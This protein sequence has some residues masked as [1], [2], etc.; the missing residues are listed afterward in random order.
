MRKK[1]LNLFVAIGAASM[2]LSSCSTLDSILSQAGN[3]ANLANC[4]YNMKDVTNVYVAGVNVKN[5]VNGNISASDVLKLSSALLSKNVP[6]TMDVNIN[7]TNPTTTNA[8]LTTMDWICEIDGTQ[9]ANGTTS[10]NYTIK[11]STTTT[12]PLAVNTNVYSMFSKNGIESLK[13]F[14]NSFQSDGTSS[15]VAIK[16]KPS[17]NAGGINISS[18]SYITLEKKTGSNTSTN[19][20]NNGSTG[21]SNNGSRGSGGTTKL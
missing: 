12:I 20:T 21:N 18:P 17:I 7:V 13:N 4:S 16:I 8:A 14:V 6:L 15:K 3:I 9:F 2:F 1:I 10:K 19:T 5:V 11:P